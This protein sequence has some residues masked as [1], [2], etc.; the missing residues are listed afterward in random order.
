MYWVKIAGEA[1]FLMEGKNQGGPALSDTREPSPGGWDWEGNAGY[2]DTVVL[3]LTQALT[4]FSSGETWPTPPPATC[5]WG[6]GLSTESWSLL[7]FVDGCFGQWGFRGRSGPTVWTGMVD[8]WASNA[9]SALWERPPDPHKVTGWCS[10]GPATPPQM[11]SVVVTWCMGWLYPFFVEG[12]WRQ[13]VAECLSV[14]QR[15]S[16]GIRNVLLQKEK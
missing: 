12:G 5:Q 14:L 11:W 2:W 1:W 10:L 8:A 7:Q 13:V 6:T 4:Q 15:G 16:S 3:L 9:F